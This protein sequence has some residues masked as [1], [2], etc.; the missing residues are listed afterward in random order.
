MVMS[1]SRMPQTQAMMGSH[2]NNMVSQPTNQGQF[3]PQGQFPAAAGGTMNV[4]V[5]MGQPITQSAVTQVRR[6]VLC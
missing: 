5:G 6:L 2:A 4:N 1:P 3:L